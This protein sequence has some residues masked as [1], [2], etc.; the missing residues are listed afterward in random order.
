MKVIKQYN[1]R[2]NIETKSD[3]FL[4]LDGIADTSKCY[5]R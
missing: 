1:E 2:E 4:L 5:P 3:I